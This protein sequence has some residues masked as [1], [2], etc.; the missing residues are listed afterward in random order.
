VRGHINYQLLP[1]LNL[2]FNLSVMQNNNPQVAIKSDYLSHLES[3]NVQWNPTAKQ[4]KRLTFLGT[5]EHQSVSS[6]ILYLMPQNLSQANS[7]YW[8]SGNTFTGLIAA[9]VPVKSRSIQFS[10]GGSFLLSDGTRATNYY[11]PVGRL[12]VPILKNLAWNSEWRY[13]GFGEAAYLYES[14]RT[15]LVTTGLRFTR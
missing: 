14:F 15:H 13:Y 12:S 10:G 5:W 4:V 1:T 3:F 9:S 6:D 11:Q 2:A 7:H 8:E